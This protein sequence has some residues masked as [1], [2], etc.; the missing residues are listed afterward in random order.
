MYSLEQYG[1]VAVAVVVLIVAVV[2]G[3]LVS[4]VRSKKPH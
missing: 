4:A 2:M 3:G 1:H